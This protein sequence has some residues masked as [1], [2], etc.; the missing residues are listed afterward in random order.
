[1]QIKVNRTPYLIDGYYVEEY[2]LLN[3]NGFELRCTNFGATITHLLWPGLEGT[4]TDILL[5]YDETEKWFSDKNWFGSTAGRCCNR[6][7]NA[8]FT[9]DGKEHNITANIPP[10]QLHGGTNGF[11]MRNWRGYPEQKS[12]YVGVRMHLLSKDGDEGF[13]GNLSV[14]ALMAITNENELIIEYKAV[15]DKPTICNITSHPYYN[16][17]GE[18]SILD[19]K[20]YIH[21]DQMLLND[22][23]SIPTGEFFNL[24]GSAF[25]FTS[26]T[27]IGSNMKIGHQQI[28][29]ANGI[30]QN[31]VLKE[32]I[33]NLPQIIVY[34]S[35][36]KKRLS[37]FT[38]QPGVQF[39][40]GNFLNLFG[41]N[42]LKYEKH[43]GLC[44]ETQGF[45]N[46]INYPH[47]PSVVLRPG[48]KYWSW[49]KVKL[50]DI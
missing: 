30:D 5:G 22:A 41:K 40:T 4:V 43:T 9:L 1:M 6:I 31:F 47:F 2:S 34:S 18:G 15:T 46:A 21:A 36:S 35:R 42:N 10:H 44:L 48:E 7:K 23:D 11:N 27:T 50:E 29:I 28:D 25:D 17:D 12:E 16:L 8:K 20:L 14:E 26:L 45:P 3:D 32:S 39:Y 33:Q 49:T 13:P 19:H 24:I 38:N 37:F